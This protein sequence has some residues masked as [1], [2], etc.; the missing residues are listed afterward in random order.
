M[1]LFDDQTASEAV[2]GLIYPIGA[3]T[4]KIHIIEE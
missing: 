4:I 2:D 3:I 1:I